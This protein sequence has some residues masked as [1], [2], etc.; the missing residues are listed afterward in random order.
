MAYFSN[1]TEGTYYEAKFCDRCTHQPPNPD[2]GGCPVFLL[3]M[4]WNYSQ[5]DKTEVG[6]AKRH[7]LNI[8]WP[9]CERG[10]NGDCKM[11]IERETKGG[12]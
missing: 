10:E 7:A 3:H 1:G 12:G 11:F 5:L 9:R 4:L 6:M 2:D 8:L